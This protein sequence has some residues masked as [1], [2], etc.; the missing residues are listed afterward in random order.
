MDISQQIKNDILN[1]V[2]DRGKA[3]R[4]EELSS[5]YG[6]SRI[7]VRDAL[8]LL[9]E[10][11]WL[12]PHGKA[13]VMIPELN[14]KDAEDLYLMRSHLESLLLEKAFD[15]ITYENIGK[16]WDIMELLDQENLSLLKRGELNW[17][18]HESL[19][20]PANRPA[21]FRMVKIINKQVTQYLGYQYGPMNYRAQSQH[22]HKQLL[23]WLQ[24]KNKK[25][26]L[27]LLKEHIEGAGKLL[28]QHLRTLTSGEK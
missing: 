18:F 23:K 1:H 13:G 22:D 4:Q 5:R 14:W 24:E 12:V 26:A 21:L 25:A 10:E 16:A 6:V 11:G 2:L 9:K 28:V 7:P 8:R 27:S 17:Q 3:L 20:L 19:Y 15:F